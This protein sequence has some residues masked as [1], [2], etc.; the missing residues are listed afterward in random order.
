MKGFPC[1]ALS[2]LLFPVAIWNV[3]YHHEP[4]YVIQFTMS[5]S[6]FADRKLPWLQGPSAMA[7]FTAISSQHSKPSPIFGDREGDIAGLIT[8]V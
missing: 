5:T 4:K 2:F 8:Y 1:P 6:I 3:W 7:H